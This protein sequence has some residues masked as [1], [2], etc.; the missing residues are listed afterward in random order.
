M[1]SPTHRTTMQKVAFFWIGGSLLLMGISFAKIFP[2]IHLA[3]LFADSDG[4]SHRFVD[5]LQTSQWHISFSM[6]IGGLLPLL[7]S[8]AINKQI[9]ISSNHFPLSRPYAIP[10]LG[11]FLSALVQWHIF[12]NIPHITDATSHWFQSK[13]FASGHV[14]IPA[15]PC[16]NAFFQHN[17]IIGPQGQWHTKYYPGQALWL[18]LPFRTWLM[19]LAFAL[20]LVATHRV[21]SRYFDAALAYFTTLLLAT[22]PLML[23]L[24]ASFMSHI[25]LLMWTSGAW[26]FLLVCID[27]TSPSRKTRSAASASGFCA[28]MALLTRP[29]DA[30]LFFFVIGACTLSPLLNQRNKWGQTTLGCLLGGILPI[31]ILLAWNHHLYGQFCATGYNFSS[32]TPLSQTPVI[33]DSFGLSAAYPWTRALGQFFWVSLR[34]NQALLGWPAALLL[35][36][37]ALILPT[38]RKTNGLLLA[39]A[40][41]LYLPY[42]FFHYY[43]FELEARYAASAAPFLIVIIARTIVSCFRQNAFSIARP[44][45][46][47]G[48]SSC[49]LYA[50]TY[51]W[52]IYLYPRYAASYEEASP[53]IHHLAQNADL[54][55][56]AVI[57]LPNEGFIYSSGFIYNDPDLHDPILYARYLPNAF[58]CLK[59]A[60]PQHHFY[61][62][63]QSSENPFRGRFLPLRSFPQGAVEQDISS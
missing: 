8:S 21:V 16:P 4:L 54:A 30:I 45:L 31:L 20:F 61:R 41:C 55:L 29:Q 10:L 38:V 33:Q 57:L 15:P 22:S 28:G 18:S 25:T 7:V 51:Y 17:V 3:R 44:V 50:A 32:G 5:L 52:P 11:F 46:I 42:Y 2:A 35:L 9:R 6:L 12:D 1:S 24:S 47:A 39:A 48:I 56:P 60:F 19:P 37:P 59:E 27:S 34:L 23:L 13:L 63:L 14:S 62:Y 49:C 40:S 58:P 53:H 43:G 36:F 26:A